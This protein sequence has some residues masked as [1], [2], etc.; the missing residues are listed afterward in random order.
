MNGTTSTKQELDVKQ[1]AQEL[2][3]A[4]GTPNIDPNG[5]W[6]SVGGVE[7][8]HWFCCSGKHLHANPDVAERC[9]R[10]K[11]KKILDGRWEEKYLFDE[12]C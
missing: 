9:C 8:Y 5:K 11:Q 10:Q 2:F 12:A 3:T 4:E 7:V 6:V 1:L